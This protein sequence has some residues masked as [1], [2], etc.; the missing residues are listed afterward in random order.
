MNSIA[1]LKAWISANFWK[2]DQVAG[3]VKSNFFLRGNH[4]HVSAGT[5]SA[6]LPIVLAADGKIDPSFIQQTAIAEYISDTA[7]AM[8]SGN[9]ETGVTVTYQDSDNTMDIVL[10]ND[11]VTNAILANMAQAT[12]KGRAAGAGTGDPADLT[13]A[14]VV[15]IL[16]GVIEPEN[17]NIPDDAS[18]VVTGSGMLTLPAGLS[19]G[20]EAL[21]V[22]DEG[23]WTPA[24]TGSTTNPTITYATQSGNYFRLGSTTSGRTITFFDFNVSVSSIS[25]GSGNLLVSLPF[26][27]IVTQIQCAALVH[28]VNWTGAPGVIT[29]E[30]TTSATGRFRT[31]YD[32]AA[33]SSILVT[34]LTNSS[35]LRASGFFRT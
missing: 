27:S 18:G 28:Q 11:A 3:W 6:A 30:P 17:I 25:G 2:S 10:N 14:Q 21:N 29:F 9:T 4:Q 34:E 12:I 13:A 15:A 5:A 26:T 31:S 8:W 20:N 35:V 24:I 23:T 19:F 16:S 33:V 7:G 22:Y 1:E 32:N